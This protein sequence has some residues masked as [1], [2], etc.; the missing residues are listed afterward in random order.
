[1][2]ERTV[3]RLYASTPCDS[4][5]GTQDTRSVFSTQLVSDLENF[6]RAET[7]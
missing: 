1:M 3:V 4:E 7:T 2:I 5:M 6:N